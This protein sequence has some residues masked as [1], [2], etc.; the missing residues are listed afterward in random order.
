MKK[1]FGKTFGYC[2]LL[3]SILMSLSF[4]SCEKSEEPEVTLTF[5][6]VT[7]VL[8][9]PG[10]LV[11]ANNE[12]RT[13]IQSIIKQACT[14]YKLPEP[15][16]NFVVVNPMNKYVSPVFLTKDALSYTAANLENG[17]TILMA[18]FNIPED[19]EIPS[20]FYVMNVKKSGGEWVAEL[21]NTDGKVILSQKPVVE[22][23]SWSNVVPGRTVGYFG[24]KY[25]V[26]FG[27]QLKDISIYMDVKL[28]TSS[29]IIIPQI[30]FAQTLTDQILAFRKKIEDNVKN[31]LS[32][33]GNL[34]I[35]SRNDAL[36]ISGLSDSGG[37]TVP[38]MFIR[39]T[40]IPADFYTISHARSQ[41]KGYNTKKLIST[42]FTDLSKYPN[43]LKEGGGG[44]GG[45][46][47]GILNTGYIGNVINGEY[48]I[49]L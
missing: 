46:L 12:F 6:Q 3:L 16:D 27:A 20:G 5:N 4:T 15:D 39:S 49:A 17:K 31:M 19:S 1:L 24:G 30:K 29:N 45:M 23:N 48:H 41:L 44:I 14:D 18:Y 7:D 25:A 37:V 11:Q 32:V 34:F 26:R 35:A 36:L 13:S 2:N 28:G 22:N 38:F 8:G 43:L 10:A 47:G 42:T 9:G 33:N 21:Q 40:N